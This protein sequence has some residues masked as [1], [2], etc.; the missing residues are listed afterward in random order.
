MDLNDARIVLI[1]NFKNNPDCLLDE[2]SSRALIMDSIPELCAEKN[3]LIV[4]YHAGLVDEIKNSNDPFILKNKYKLILTKEFGYSER[5][6]LWCIETWL[7]IVLGLSSDEIS[8]DNINYDNSDKNKVIVVAKSEY[9]R[10]LEEISNLKALITSLTAE[11]DELQ[12]H[13][14]RDLAADYNRKIGEL[15]L[16][17]LNTKLNVLRLKR[18]IEILQS[19]INRQER[20]SEKKAKEQANQEYKEFEDNLNRKAEEA[21]NANQYK[22]EEEQKE[23]EWEKE[24]EAQDESEQEK[25]D[26]SKSDKKR[27]YKSRTDEMKALYRK[28]VKAL[29]PDMNPDETD[30]EKEMFNEA[31][32]AYNNGN[33]NKLREIAA[34]IDE[35]KIR[36]TPYSVSKED[37]EKLKEIIEGL[38]LRVEELIS[39]IE[40]IKNTF[41]YNMKEFLSN[42]TAVSERQSELKTMLKEYEELEEELEKRFS[43]MLGK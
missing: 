20:K 13:E 42:E 31:V 3:I 36:E 2:Q 18:M 37:I 10:L 14:C 1:D 12:F 15:E 40:N 8:E 32:D 43:Q 27:Q 19:Q 24:S 7:L 38:K 28:I 17:V 9:E 22:E 33:L 6:S 39:K 11:R 35:G 21:R 4:L 41:P 5:I 34:L 29:H 30:V 23:E 16:K 26:D 25:T